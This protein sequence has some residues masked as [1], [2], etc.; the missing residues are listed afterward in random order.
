[1]K[2]HI[3]ISNDKSH[4][5]FF[6][7]HC[8]LL[9]WQSVLDKSFQPAQNCMWSNGC[10]SQFKSRIPWYF[11]SPYP[12]MMGGCTMRWSFFGISHGKGPHDGIGAILKRFIGHR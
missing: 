7:Y 11:V 10:F 1:M 5:N 12:Y 6:V 9:H 3:Y 2:Y 8:L 4:D